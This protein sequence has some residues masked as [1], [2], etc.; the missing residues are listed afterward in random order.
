MSDFWRCGRFD[1]GGYS[2][3]IYF[4]VYWVSCHLALSSLMAD[5]GNRLDMC[6]V[7]YISL[8]QMA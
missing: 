2:F 6:G 5:L 7:V 8:M 1:L 4:C 3:E